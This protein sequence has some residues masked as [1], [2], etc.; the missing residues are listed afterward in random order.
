VAWQ[1]QLLT[2]PQTLEKLAAE[3]KALVYVVRFQESPPTPGGAGNA[4]H[5][6][7]YIVLHAHA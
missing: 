6:L 2:M 3:G 4:A 7:A 1:V 5:T